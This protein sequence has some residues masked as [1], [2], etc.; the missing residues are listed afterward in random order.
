MTLYFE[1]KLGKE[2]AVVVLRVL[3]TETGFGLVAR[4]P[5]AVD[6]QLPDAPSPH[7]VSL[8]AAYADGSLRLEFHLE[9]REAERWCRWLVEQ[10]LARG[11]ALQLARVA[12]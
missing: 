12:R 2:Q 8:E 6:L 9:E 5:F 7:A 4:G 3:E 10:A 11:I 1:G